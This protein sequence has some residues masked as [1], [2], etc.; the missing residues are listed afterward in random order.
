MDFMPYEK[1]LIFT[2]INLSLVSFNEKVQKIKK[3][4]SKTEKAGTRN[5]KSGHIFGCILH[6]KNRLSCK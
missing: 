5:L 6:S 1:L 2:L 4:L 3:E